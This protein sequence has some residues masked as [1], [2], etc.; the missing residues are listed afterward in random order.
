[1]NTLGLLYLASFERRVVE[2]VSPNRILGSRVF[3]TCAWTAAMPGVDDTSVVHS[4]GL[5]VERATLQN[6][7]HLINLLFIPRLIT[8]AHG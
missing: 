5:A 2:D 6:D 3:V 8:P 7:A 1:V 4:I